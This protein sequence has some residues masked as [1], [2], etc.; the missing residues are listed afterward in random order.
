MFVEKECVTNAWLSVTPSPS[1]ETLYVVMY[2]I[3]F[4]FNRSNYNGYR[5]RHNCKYKP[6]P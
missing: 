3:V 1:F 6:N 2:C 4:E 5:T